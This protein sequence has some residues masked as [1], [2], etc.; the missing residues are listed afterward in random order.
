MAIAGPVPW[1]DQS[2][3]RCLTC[4]VESLEVG[5][6]VRHDPRQVCI[7]GK[8]VAERNGP[9]AHRLPPIPAQ[10]PDDV[11]SSA[12]DV[13]P[14]GNYLVLAIEKKWEPVIDLVA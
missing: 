4:V 1:C 14:L 9:N 2:T 5:Q 3:K 11:R 10:I 7:D 13:G 6:G 8:A 12:Y